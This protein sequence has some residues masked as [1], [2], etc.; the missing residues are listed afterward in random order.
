M[1]TRRTRQS[2]RVKLHVELFYDS[3]VDQWGYTVPVISIIGT[4]CSS[5]EEAKGFALE[6]I[7][8]TLESG[9]DEIDPEADVVALDV[10]LEKVS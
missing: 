10:T 2:R 5:R 3:E 6:A 9:E 1:A 4:G 7:K 8:F